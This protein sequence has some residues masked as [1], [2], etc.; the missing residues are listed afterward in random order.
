MLIKTT[1]HDVPSKLDPNGRKIRIFVISPNI[2][3]YPHAKFPGKSWRYKVIHTVRSAVLT[4]DGSKAL[5]YSGA[6]HRISC[7]VSRSSKDTVH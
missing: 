4:H 2:P 6:H 7:T 5:S 3:G 1:Y